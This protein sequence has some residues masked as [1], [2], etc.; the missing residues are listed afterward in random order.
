MSGRF[1]TL[2]EVVPDWGPGEVVVSVGFR[3]K[4]QG[5]VDVAAL[6]RRLDE[7]LHPNR[8]KVA[9]GPISVEEK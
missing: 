3:C 8:H 4:R 1:S 6:R 2:A 7:L 9:V 5:E